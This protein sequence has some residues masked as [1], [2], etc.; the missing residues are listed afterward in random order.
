ME[1]IKHELKIRHHGKKPSIY[2]KKGKFDDI[3]GV[4]A[5]DMTKR[6]TV[7][8]STS[9]CTMRRIGEGLVT[10]ILKTNPKHG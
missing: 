5:T 4:L 1:L 8:Y 6:S 9:S 3:R 7:Q 2:Y 10:R